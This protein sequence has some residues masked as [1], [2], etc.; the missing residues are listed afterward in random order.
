MH[1]SH[2]FVCLLVFHWKEKDMRLIESNFYNTN[3]TRTLQIL[4]SYELEE[5]GEGYPKIPEFP[6][7]LPVLLGGITSLIVFYRIKFK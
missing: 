5:V 1:S 2:L 4:S 7:A 6:F 3:L